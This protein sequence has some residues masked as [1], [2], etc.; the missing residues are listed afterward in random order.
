M[1]R[2]VASSVSKSG[3]SIANGFAWIAGLLDL[4]VDFLVA[5]VVD[6]LDF[7]GFLDFLD[8]LEDLERAAVFAMNHFELK[9]SSTI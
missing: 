2:V 3:N 1:R 6:L 8:L 9:G 7:L 4:R 5:F